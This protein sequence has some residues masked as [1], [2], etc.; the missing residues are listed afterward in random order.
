MNFQY[1]NR[2]VRIKRI[3]TFQK[4]LRK[5]L[6]DGIVV[7]PFSRMYNSIPDL[8]P[9]SPSVRNRIFRPISVENGLAALISINVLPI[10][11]VDLI[12]CQG[13]T[14]F[15]IRQRLHLHLW[16]RAQGSIYW[17]TQ[18]ISFW[19]QN[20]DNFQYICHYLIYQQSDPPPKRA[21]GKIGQRTLLFKSLQP[22]LL[23]ITCQPLVVVG[24]VPNSTSSRTHSSLY[25]RHVFFCF[26]WA[27][28]DW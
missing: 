26:L 25:T 20:T 15:V 5:A 8:R 24:L 12:P 21:S 14:F 4:S 22:C 1:S 10:W 13:M 2:A 27:T 9:G 19:D 6:S 16:I 18:S 7:R 11:A 23:L 3:T 17:V 28:L